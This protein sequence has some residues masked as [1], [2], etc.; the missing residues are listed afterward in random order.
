M[1][2]VVVETQANIRAAL[3]FLLEQQPDFQVLCALGPAPDLVA[4]LLAL[5]P[6]V[7]LL[8]WELPRRLA[9]RILLALR[10]SSSSPRIV[11]LSARSEDE[12][13]ARAAGAAAF[14]S[15]DE[16]PAALLRALHPT[17]NLNSPAS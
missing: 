2:I 7:I 14:V 6:E 1:R 11:V 16:A 10:R 8:D 3:A 5:R 4:R 9:S 12:A 17:E 13:K 15:K